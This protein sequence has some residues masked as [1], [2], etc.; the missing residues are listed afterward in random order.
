[1]PNLQMPCL[2]YIALA[3]LFAINVQ[4]LKLQNFIT[5]KNAPL[6][7]YNATPKIGKR[8]TLHE[9]KKHWP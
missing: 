2:K 8:E 4:L 6:N 7:T 5:N 3:M 9:E 1:M